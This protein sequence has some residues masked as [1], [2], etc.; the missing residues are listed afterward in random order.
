MI[1]KLNMVRVSPVQIVERVTRYK[2]APTPD[3]LLK[4]SESWPMV[5]NTV[6]VTDTYNVY[7]KLVSSDRN[8]VNAYA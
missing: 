4:Q 5:Q 3:E 8:T 1:D 7:G 2:A 6:I